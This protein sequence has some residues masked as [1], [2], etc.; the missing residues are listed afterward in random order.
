M[1]EML[2]LTVR[3]ARRRGV[4]VAV[5]VALSTGGCSSVPDAA[6]PVE[7][8]KG[9]RDWISGDDK[10]DEAKKTEPKPVPGADKSFPKLESVPQR[11]PQTTAADRE[12]MANTLIAD[13]DTARYSDEK[14]RRQNSSIGAGSLP[15][16]ASASPVPAAKPAQV[17]SVPAAPSQKVVRQAIPS[18]AVAPP[19]R[20]ARTLPVMPN[21]PI[22][23]IPNQVPSSVGLPRPPQPVQ[24]PAVPSLSPPPPPPVMF[25]SSAPPLGAFPPRPLEFPE[26][27]PVVNP[28]GGGPAFGRA[29]PPVQPG[30]VFGESDRFA[31]QPPNDIG[32]PQ[33]PSFVTPSFETAQSLQPNSAP[34]ATILF[35]DG[36]ARIGRSDRQI[37]RRVYNDYRT[38]GGRIHVIGHSSSRTRNLDQV[39]HQLAN[40]SISYARAR[41]VA[42]VLEQMGVP[43]A[44]IVVTAMSDQEPA[45]FEVMPAGEAGNRRTEIYF[46]N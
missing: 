38:R 10:V 32:L 34:V 42:G 30:Q 44:A 13:R 46:E 35:A 31:P 8:Y 11:P 36:S 14:F 28:S 7:W 26:R 5:L 17:A 21:Q 16:P 22:A 12:K 3:Q 6:N 2:V 33:Q 15:R 23:V 43:S 20:S 19:A 29:A 40:F 24:R 27:P 18:A 4:L 9:T 41:S 25:G 39:S 37:I 45:F 1:K